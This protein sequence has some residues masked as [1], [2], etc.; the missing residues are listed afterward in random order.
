MELT[1]V[2]TQLAGQIA[3]IA[4]SKSK[5]LDEHRRSINQ[6]NEVL[7]RSPNETCRGQLDE[8]KKALERLKADYRLLISNYKSDETFSLE[9]IAVR[10]IQSGSTVSFTN[11]PPLEN[12]LNDSYATH[13]V[14]AAIDYA[15]AIGG[16]SG[17][18]PKVKFVF[19]DRL[20]KRIDFNTHMRSDYAPLHIA[21]LNAA[22]KYAQRKNVGFQ[23]TVRDSAEPVQ[24]FNAENI[25]SSHTK[26]EFGT[27][28]SQPTIDANLSLDLPTQVENVFNQQRLVITG[29][30]EIITKA[31]ATFT[32]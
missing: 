20:I 15:R 27:D 7:C 19:E 2:V 18:E 4:R 29:R 25:Y 14:K 11:F 3:V 22:I 28:L 12:Y 31:L 9:G 16:E 24:E 1:D 30:I 23:V 8:A 17:A 26:Y 13:L 21:M 5:D 10:F 32:N 6:I